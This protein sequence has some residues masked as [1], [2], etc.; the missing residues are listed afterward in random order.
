MPC[1]LNGTDSYK[2]KFSGVR[3]GALLLN[4]CHTTSVPGWNRTC[5]YGRWWPGLCSVFPPQF[6][7]HRPSSLCQFRSV[8]STTLSLSQSPFFT[9]TCSVSCFGFSPSTPLPLVTVSSSSSP[10][11]LSAGAAAIAV[12]PPDVQPAFVRLVEVEADGGGE[13]VCWWV[14]QTVTDV[15]IVSYRFIHWFVWTVMDVVRRRVGHVYSIVCRPS[16]L[17][18]QPFC[19]V[20]VWFSTMSQISWLM[21]SAAAVHAG[22]AGRIGLQT[23]P[24]SKTALP[25]R[26]T[27]TINWICP[28]DKHLAARN[29]IYAT[30]DKNKKKISHLSFNKLIHLNP[31]LTW[32]LNHHKFQLSLSLNILLTSTKS[33][34][35]IYSSDYFWGWILFIHHQQERKMSCDDYSN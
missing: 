32:T 4:E 35:R 10:V 21:C 1:S 16:N 11:I 27:A 9:V 34:D 33:N 12:S 8:T 20:C 18:F 15:Q 22:T 28:L 31:P 17:L 6:H 23:T 7:R 26:T 29:Y 24:A 19:L 14:E 2:C 25:Q 3:E 13:K 30:G 5:C